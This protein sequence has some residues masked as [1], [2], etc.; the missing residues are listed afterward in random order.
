MSKSN[1]FLSSLILVC[2]V[3]PSST[4]A[5]P[6]WPKWVPARP[7]LAAA[8]KDAITVNTAAELVRELAEAK[9]QATILLADGIYE[10]SEILIVRSAGLTLRSAGGDA[11]K[12][13]IDAATCRG[14]EGIHIH[15]DDVTIAEITIRNVK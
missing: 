12:V 1:I 7:P 13:V 11:A 3:A 5:A 15:A 8:P 14:G 10:I 9:P 6:V 2:F 4:F